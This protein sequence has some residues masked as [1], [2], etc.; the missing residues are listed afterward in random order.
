[1]Y[2]YIYTHLLTLPVGNSNGARFFFNKLVAT[3]E[4]SWI[5]CATKSVTTQV[6]R[7]LRNQDKWMAP[8]PVFPSN[9]ESAVY[10]LISKLMDFFYC[11]S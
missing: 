3:S 10:Q 7:V 6:E 9:C 4:S 1:M 5:R 11:F 8:C 2:V